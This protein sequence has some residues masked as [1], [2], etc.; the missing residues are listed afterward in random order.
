MARALAERDEKWHGLPRDGASQHR[1]KMPC[2]FSGQSSAHQSQPHPW[3]NALEHTLDRGWVWNLVLILGIQPAGKA[4]ACQYRR[5]QVRSLGQEDRLEEE[6]ATHSSIPAGRI[7]WTGDYSPWGCKELDMTEVT[8]AS[9]HAG[10]EGR[11][12]GS[13]CLRK[14]S[15]GTTGKDSDVTHRADDPRKHTASRSLHETRSGRGEKTQTCL[16]EK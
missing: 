15:F 4:S 3:E 11:A 8:N 13:F 9:A 1:S 7:P 6:M 5:P 2:P 14:Q 16:V 12:Q 10:K